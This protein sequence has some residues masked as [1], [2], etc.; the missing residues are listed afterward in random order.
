MTIS[1]VACEK[2]YTKTTLLVACVALV[3]LTSSK[4][5]T[6]RMHQQ[7]WHLSTL[8]G[9]GPPSLND[10]HTWTNEDLSINAFVALPEVRILLQDPGNTL[11]WEARLATLDP[12]Y[13]TR[14]FAMRFG[15]TL[16]ARTAT[17]GRHK[18]ERR[19][20]HRTSAA[21]DALERSGDALCSKDCEGIPVLSLTARWFARISKT[22]H[23]TPIGFNANTGDGPM[24]ESFRGGNTVVNA[25]SAAAADSSYSGLLLRRIAPFIPHLTS[26]SH[27]STSLLLRRIA[28]PISH[29]TTTCTYIRVGNM[30]VTVGM[31][32]GVRV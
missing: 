19:H 25:V 17:P 2:L 26:P 24:Y 1:A 31:V 12:A 11:A 20:W 28:L 29:L 9:A 14:E 15:I 5:R 13:L 16:H 4:I 21:A 8:T 10:L 7:R 6:S 27:L 3:C 30:C 22:L 32:S 18:V 23:T